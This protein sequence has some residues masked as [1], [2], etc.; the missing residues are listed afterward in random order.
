MSSKLL[1]KPNSLFST[2]SSNSPQA[3]YLFFIPLVEIKNPFS[4]LYLSKSLSVPPG[5]NILLPKPKLLYSK[6]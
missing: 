6:F 1:P 3:I 2:L 4:T 5:V